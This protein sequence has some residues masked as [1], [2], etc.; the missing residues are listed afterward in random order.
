MDFEALSEAVKHLNENSNGGVTLEAFKSITQRQFLE[1][2]GIKARLKQLLT[3]SESRENAAHIKEDLE[4][5]CSRLIDKDG[6]GASYRFWSMRSGLNSNPFP[7][8]AGAIK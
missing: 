4:S 8:N 7:F 3:A 5:G 6:M 1:T 2:M